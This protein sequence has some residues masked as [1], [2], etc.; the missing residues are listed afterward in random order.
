MNHLRM[1]S[2]GRN[3]QPLVQVRSRRN[4]CTVEGEV[5]ALERL[6]QVMKALTPRHV[7][8]VVCVAKMLKEHSNLQ[9]ESCASG[10]G[11][12]EV[13]AGEEVCR[14]VLPRMDCL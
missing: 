14:C 6:S 2:L 8:V 4:W 10:G 9:G 13:E 7:D 1:L 12:L 11:C 3:P 5:Q